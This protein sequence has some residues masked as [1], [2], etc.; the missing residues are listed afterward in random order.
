MLA[1]LML[2]FRVAPPFIPDAFG[3]DQSKLQAQ[4]V[5]ST[6]KLQE[7]DAKRF[8]ILNEMIRVREN[9]AKYLKDLREAPQEL[10]AERQTIEIRLQELQ[11]QLVS[12]MNE[13]IGI[14]EKL[15]AYQPA[16]PTPR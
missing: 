12:T 14:I 10:L 6:R 4:L 8:E 3:Q 2:A 9:T 7:I 15:R 11:G 5:D 16:T 1:A 13:I